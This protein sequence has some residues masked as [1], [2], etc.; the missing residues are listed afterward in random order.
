MSVVNVSL[1]G[2]SPYFGHDYF[3][4]FIPHYPIRKDIYSHQPVSVG[5]FAD[6]GG[7]P[8][9]LSDFNESNSLILS[10]FK[11]IMQCSPDEPDL[12]GKRGSLSLIKMISAS[13]EIVELMCSWAETR[14]GDWKSCQDLRVKFKNG[15]YPQEIGNLLNSP[16]NVRLYR[17]MSNKVYFDWPWGMDRM[18]TPKNGNLLPVEYLTKL[19]NNF[20]DAVFFMG[21]E[22]PYMPWKH[23]FPAFSSS[24]ALNTADIPWPW[25]AS[26]QSELHKYYNGHSLKLMEWSERIPKAAFAGYLSEVRQVFFDVALRNPDLIDAHWRGT[27]DVPP[28]HPA[29]TE[30]PMPEDR[31]N[32]FY[33]HIPDKSINTGYIEPLLSLR[34][35]DAV[36]VIGQYK[37]L[38][39][40]T[41][42]GGFATADRLAEYLTYSG[43][44]VLLQESEFCYHFTER[45]KPWVHYV[46]ISYSAADVAEKVRW[47][48]EHDD[49]AQR[50]QLNAQNFAKSYLRLEDYF[51]YMATALDSI[52]QIQK[53]T[54]ALDPFSPR[55][56]V[57]H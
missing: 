28:W 9:K 6:V 23:P 31:E 53:G 17:V 54:S 16:F 35:D 41:G 3:P 10:R 15:E 19:I 56:L 45:L 57:I 4:R 50:I 26:F 39:V 11:E 33:H 24:P 8:K 29:S 43:S 38:V 32:T 1:V 21:E 42:A 5:R 18:A 27:S 52:A 44:V 49:L 30:D 47:L 14:C 13:S 25:P 46:P 48:R 51:C 7:L 12:D 36:N 2:G 55:E 22:I 34:V 40:L 20:D 37:Y